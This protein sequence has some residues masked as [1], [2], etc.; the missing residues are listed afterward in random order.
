MCTSRSERSE[1][2]RKDQEGRDRRKDGWM[3]VELIEWVRW[4]L[5][6]PNTL[7]FAEFSF[8]QILSRS[9]IEFEITYLGGMDGSVFIVDSYY[10][11]IF[12]LCTALVSAVVSRD[13]LTSMWNSI[14]DWF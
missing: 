6:S 4:T 1:R 8:F 7:V 11:A 12:I 5:F 9:M 2:K 3:K 10:C 14:A 13:N